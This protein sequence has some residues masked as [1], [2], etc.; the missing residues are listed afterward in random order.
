MFGRNGEPDRLTERTCGQL[1]EDINHE[2][3]SQLA[4][5]DGEVVQ[6]DTCQATRPANVYVL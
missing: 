2:N 1:S 6:Q 5:E 3:I 4:N